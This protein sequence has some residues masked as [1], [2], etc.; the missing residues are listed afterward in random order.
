MDPALIDRSGDPERKNAAL[1]GDAP[2]PFLHAEGK[3]TLQESY[4]DDGEGFPTEEDLRSLRR[5]P[6]GIPWKIY[7][8]AFVELCERMSYYGTTAVYSNFIAKPAPTRTGAALN[9]HDE[10]AQPGALGLGKQV[11]FSLTTFNAFWVYCCPLLG[12][13]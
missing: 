7:T 3:A 1:H 5:V 4:L 13:W 2:P 12:A 11:A 8:I 10:E 6:A 9:P